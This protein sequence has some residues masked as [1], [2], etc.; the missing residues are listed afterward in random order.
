MM[1][2]DY[3]PNVFAIVKMMSNST[4]SWMGMLGK[5]AFY[6]SLSLSYV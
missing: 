3:I 5:S 4:F 6:T 1:H 2:A